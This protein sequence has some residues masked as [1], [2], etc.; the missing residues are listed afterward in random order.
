MWIFYWVNCG[1]NVYTIIIMPNRDIT[2]DYVMRRSLRDSLSGSFLQLVRQSSPS[3][4]WRWLR[5]HTS[6]A[7]LRFG[8]W[9]LELVQGASGGVNML[10]VHQADSAETGK[11][12]DLFSLEGTFELSAQCVKQVDCVETQYAGNYSIISGCNS[13]QLRGCSLPLSALLRQQ[14]VFKSASLVNKKP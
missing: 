14:Q 11:L 6:T 12:L 3:F 10:R 8:S 1:F 4:S 7:R 2:A 9:R 13:N 5:L